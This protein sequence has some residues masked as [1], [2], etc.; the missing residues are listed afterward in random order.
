M[1]LFPYVLA[2][3]ASCLVKAF[4]SKSFIHNF[5]QFSEQLLLWIMP[6][7]TV[8]HFSGSIFHRSWKHANTSK[9]STPNI[10]FSSDLTANFLMIAFPML[11]TNTLAGSAVEDNLML[12][13]RFAIPGTMTSSL[14]KFRNLTS[15]NWFWLISQGLCMTITSCLVPL[16]HL[17]VLRE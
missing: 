5:M 7:L 10:S 4:L 2:I 16:M 9:L 8:F 15:S 1:N 6:C 12:K 11:L 17:V 14:P 13:D 3:A